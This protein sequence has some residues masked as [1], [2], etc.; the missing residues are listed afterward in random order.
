MRG[1][2]ITIT[3]TYPGK[4]KLAFQFLS[5]C[6]YICMYTCASARVSYKGGG[7]TDSPSLPPSSPPLEILKL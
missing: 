1:G 6:V 3:K 5:V 7:G 4:Y 2:D